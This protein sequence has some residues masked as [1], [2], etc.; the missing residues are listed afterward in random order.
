M[1]QRFGGKYSPDGS[2]T[3]KGDANAPTPP[4]PVLDARRT[5]LGARTNTMFL[6]PLPLALAAFGRDATGLVMT[7]VAL[8]LML[9][10]AFLLRE[11][12]KA[13]ESYDARNVAKRPAIPR[14]L[15]AAVLTGAGLALGVLGGG[16]ALIGA[17]L[18]GALGAGLHIAA[19]GLDPMKDK[20]AEGVDE[21]QSARVARVVDEA[22]E[23]LAEMSDA[24]KRARARPLELAVEQFKTSARALC[25]QVEEDPRD[26]SGA[27]KYL[28][29]YLR[30]ARDATVKFADFYAQSRDGKAREDYLA[31]L[32]DLE[33]NFAARR[34]K[35]LLDD[36]SDLDVEI[37][38]LRERLEQEGVKTKV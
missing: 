35:L 7:L 30:G 33:T 27:R 31:L 13:E 23:Y 26:L 5:R 3:P 11:G 18:L 28:G 17:G 8:G 14:K 20:G 6:L 25:R 15:F 38:V 29:V 32:A 12:L 9:A 2:A 34:E 21:Y 10:G 22:E 19:F 4:R 16:G 1:A 24:I 36:R 37:E